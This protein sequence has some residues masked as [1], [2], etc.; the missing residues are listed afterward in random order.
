MNK[1]HKSVENDLLKLKASPA[2]GAKIIRKVRIHLTKYGPKGVP[3]GRVDAQKRGYGSTP[4]LPHSRINL[5]V[6][7]S[8]AMR[9]PNELKAIR[10]LRPRTPLPGPKTLVKKR[11]AATW[12]EASRSALGTGRNY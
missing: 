3:N 9:L 8:T 1:H 12:V 11:L 2:G 7:R 5:D 6:P 10:K 4:C